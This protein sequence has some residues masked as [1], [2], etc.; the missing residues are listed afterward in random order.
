[1]LTSKRPGLGISPHL[2]GVLIGRVAREDIEAD[3]WITWD[4]I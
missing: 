2:A 4:M 1:M 3:Q